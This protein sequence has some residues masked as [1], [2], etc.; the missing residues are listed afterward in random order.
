MDSEITPK[1]STAAWKRRGLEPLSAKLIEL[2]ERRRA[3]ITKSEEA[4][5]RRNAALEGNRPGQ[6]EEGRGHRRSL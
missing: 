4:Q 2:D 1:P 3:A 5:A 6:G